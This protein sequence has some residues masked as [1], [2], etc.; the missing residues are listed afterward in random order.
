MRC[1]IA[2]NGH[3][4]GY[5]ES[6]T[7]PVRLELIGN[8]LLEIRECIIAYHGS[9]TVFCSNYLPAN[10]VIQDNIF[11]GNVGGVSSQGW[12]GMS[13]A[14]SAASGDNNLNI[15]PRS[16]LRL[17]MQTRGVTIDFTPFPPRWAR[18]LLTTTATSV[19]VLA[20]TTSAAPPA[21]G[22][23]SYSA[24]TSRKIFRQAVDRRHLS[25]GRP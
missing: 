25:Q 24:P 21:R 20:H 9:P 16:V 3:N 12:C 4:L 18:C 13:D 1:T 2:A 17:L 8:K 14:A 10:R 7:F 5:L 23:D 22:R 6:G 15:I 11:Y 19:T